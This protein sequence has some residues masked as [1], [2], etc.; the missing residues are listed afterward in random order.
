L[1][2]EKIG[3]SA[4]HP[5][6][7]NFLGKVRNKLGKKTE[8]NRPKKSQEYVYA[9]KSILLD[10]ISPTFIEE[11]KNEIEILR[12]LD[13]PNIVKA[14]EVFI[15]KNKEIYL[16]LEYC[17]GGDLYTRAPYSEKEAARIVSKLCSAVRYMHE[18]SVIHR[19]K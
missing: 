15:R 3:G 17:S 9:L 6:P 1:R 5:H 13:H 14:H 12:C 19:G 10:R 2:E 18:H 16:V 4:F 8:E 7:K 11:L